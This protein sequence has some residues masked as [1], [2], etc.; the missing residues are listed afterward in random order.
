[1]NALKGVEPVDCPA[2]I[3]DMNDGSNMAVGLIGWQPVGCS[4]ATRGTRHERRRR[5]DNTAVSRSKCPG[6]K[7]GHADVSRFFLRV[8]GFHSPTQNFPDF[9]GPYGVSPEYFG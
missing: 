9:P 5:V 8:G 4:E 3:T 6:F 7:S 2:F 1:M